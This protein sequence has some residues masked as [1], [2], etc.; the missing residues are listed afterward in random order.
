MPEFA[1]YSKVVF[2]NDTADI[3]FDRSRQWV[4]MNNG[5][6]S[7]LFEVAGADKVFHPAKAW[8]SRNH[9]F[10]KSEMVKEP[11]AVRY[12][13]KDWAVGDLFHDGLPVSSFRT[14]TW[15]DVQ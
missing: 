12:A 4:Y 5:P 8:V 11:V 10:V 9:V 7:D 1:T 2:R 13:F 6:Q 14:D 3:S 15:D